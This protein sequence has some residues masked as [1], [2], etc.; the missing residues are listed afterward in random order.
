M[1][2]NKP[3]PYIISLRNHFLIASTISFI[4]VFILI[5]LQPFGSNNFS[6]PYKTIYFIG[7]GVISFIIYL[8]THLVS[9]QYYVRFKI[10]KRGEEFI[11]SFLY[12]SIAIIIAFLY[13]E[14]IINKQPE[15]LNLKWFLDWFKIMFLGFGSMLFVV[16]ILLR[17]YYGSNTLA[18]K[19]D[20]L[21]GHGKHP[22]EKRILLQGTLKKEAF[23]VDENSIMFAKSEDNY[24]SLYFI[25]D[26]VIHEKILR[27]TLTNISQQLPKLVKAHRSYLINPNYIIAL[28]G[29]AQ[30]AKLWLKNLEKPVPISKTYFAS[31]KALTN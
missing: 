25:E 21:E 17:N 20:S 15:R 12:I 10:W 27:N 11:F 9:K 31:I 14:I 30:N 6:S 24:V 7:Y 4:V 19:N 18:T 23:W 3:F 29:N 5:F 1:F 22:T 13:T 26:D 28:K 16:T 2:F 8:V